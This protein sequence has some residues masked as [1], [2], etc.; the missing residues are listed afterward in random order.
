MPPG[1][2]EKKRRLI[3]A[4]DAGVLRAVLIAIGNSAPQGLRG[5][6]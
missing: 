6:R 4:L 5:R 2:R 3:A 1:G